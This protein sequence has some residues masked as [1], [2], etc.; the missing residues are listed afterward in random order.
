MDFIS[1]FLYIEEFTPVICI[2]SPSPFYI[3]Y[4]EMKIKLD[5]EC[6]K[7]ISGD[8]K[9]KKTKVDKNITNLAKSI[10]DFF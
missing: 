9:T 10:F 7:N 6:K 4:K 5:C 3:I 1:S 2:L 8:I